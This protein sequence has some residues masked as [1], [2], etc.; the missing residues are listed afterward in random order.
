MYKHSPKLDQIQNYDGECRT[1]L[2][3]YVNRTQF[4]LPIEIR[5]RDGVDAFI[6]TMPPGGVVSSTTSFSGA[7]GGPRDRRQQSD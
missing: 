5:R 7:C 6:V 1:G 4:L 3:K 2:Y